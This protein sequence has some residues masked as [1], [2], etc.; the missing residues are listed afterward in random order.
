MLTAE[1]IAAEE[2]M[3]EIAAK[4][5]A[6]RVRAMRL[7]SLLGDRTR[8]VATV[9]RLEDE[10]HPGDDVVLLERIVALCNELH[11]H[12]RTSDIGLP[13][14]ESDDAIWVSHMPAGLSL[15][16]VG[17]RIF[18]GALLASRQFAERH[19]RELADAR[20]ELVATNAALAAEF[21]GYEV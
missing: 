19:A 13:M 15:K 11:P 17:P 6:R 2:T 20:T 12:T 5:T 7:E 1:S 10:A 8:L 14:W 4:E 3:S 16:K 9:R 21:P 18:Q